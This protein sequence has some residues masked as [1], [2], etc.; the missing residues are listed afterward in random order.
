[1]EMM[2]INNKYNKIGF[3][4]KDW[5]LVR[6]QDVTLSKSYGPRFSGES[7]ND[8]G[9]VKTIR[10]TDFTK[11]GKI[12][13]NQVPTA[14]LDQKVVDTHSLIENDLIIVT[15]AECGLSAVFQEQAFPFI[16]S[17]YAVKSNV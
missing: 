4:P 7:Y 15:T 5:N 11:D 1:M 3:I 13:Y 6:F 9:N 14:L 2:K 12:L 17:A 8:K 10:G 16:P